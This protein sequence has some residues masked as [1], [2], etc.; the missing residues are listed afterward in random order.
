MHIVGGQPARA[1]ELLGMKYANT[2]QGGLRNILGGRD[3]GSGLGVGVGLRT[4]GTA[5][6]VGRRGQRVRHKGNRVRRIERA[7]F[8]SDA[9][10]GCR[11]ICQFV[12][13]LLMFVVARYQHC[14]HGLMLE[15]PALGKI[16]GLRR[17][18]E[19]IGN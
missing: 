17:L 5:A 8:G 16:Q 1:T 6:R 4:G 3:S 12:V 9:T 11:V 15:L 19:P 18:I 7:W 2:K 10:G 13:E 14:L